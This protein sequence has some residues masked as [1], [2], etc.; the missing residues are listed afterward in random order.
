M[1]PSVDSGHWQ[2]IFGRNIPRRMLSSTYF[3]LHGLD[4]TGRCVDQVLTRELNAHRRIRFG[5]PT[6]KTTRGAGLWTSG[7]FE[8]SLEPARLPT[9]CHHDYQDN[10]RI[11]LNCL[12][13]EDTRR[14]RRAPSV[15][16]ND[17]GC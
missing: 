17:D 14:H 9:A 12:L 1:L 7:Q 6:A 11:K 5:A 2:H 3:G 16:S 15:T 4:E 13:L 8:L 10:L